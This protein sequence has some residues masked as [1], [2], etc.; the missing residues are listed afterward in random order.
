MN[1][2]VNKL[3]SDKTDVRFL[4]KVAEKTAKLVKSK[5]SDL[6]I[7]VVCDARM[8]GLNKK[9]L[10]KNK[11]TDVLA[12]DYGEI[13]ICLPQAKRQAKE[14]NLSTKQELATL[15]IHGIL[16]LSGYDDG[17]KK[18]FNKMKIKQEGIWQK[19]KS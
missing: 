8:K 6:S 13:V 11:T 14:F 17:T 4:K 12:F 15:L 16:H 2:E 3:T 5:I 19:I 18:D 9:H 7:A 10:N 1:I